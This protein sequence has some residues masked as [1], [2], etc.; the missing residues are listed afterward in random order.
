MNLKLAVGLGNPDARYKNT[1]H[2]AGF[3]AID[4]LTRSPRFRELFPEAV[5]EKSDDAMNHSGRAVARLLEERGAEPGELL[6][7]HDDS[8]IPIGRAK[9]SFGR[10]AAGHRGVLDV[11]RALGTDRFFRLRIGIRPLRDFEKPARR[12]KAGAFV[13]KKIAP[14]D[15]DALTAALEVSLPQLL[16]A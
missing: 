9:L 16:T 15:R 4:W 10:G 11:M 5:L 7:I 12:Q 1:Y 8:D 13:L 3:L 14:R 6:V 2:N